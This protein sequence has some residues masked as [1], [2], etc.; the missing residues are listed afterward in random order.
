MLNLFVFSLLGSWLTENHL[1]GYLHINP[2]IRGFVHMAG[3][4]KISLMLVTVGMIVE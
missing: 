4:A 3:M 1:S 2:S